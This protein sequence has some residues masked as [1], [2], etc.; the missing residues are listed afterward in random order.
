MNSMSLLKQKSVTNAQA[1]KLFDLRW[2]IFSY[3]IDIYSLKNHVGARQSHSHH[4]ATLKLLP[5][6]LLQLHFRVN[7]AH[8]SP[9]TR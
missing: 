6:P 8:H 1:R 5:V 3:I 7:T 9:I 4:S 2:F